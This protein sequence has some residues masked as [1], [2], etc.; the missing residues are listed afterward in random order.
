MHSQDCLRDQLNK[1]M[2]EYGLTTK[3]VAIIVDI[4]PHIIQ[5]FIAYDYS[6]QLTIFQIMAISNF[7]HNKEWC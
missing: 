3:D 2:G 5:R 6:C 4:D 7:C 1:V